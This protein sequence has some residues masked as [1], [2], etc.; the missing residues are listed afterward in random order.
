[1]NK[2][3]FRIL[4]IS[5]IIVTLA[6]LLFFFIDKNNKNKKVTENQPS[7]FNS[8]IK[9]QTENPDQPNNII[10]DSGVAEIFDK[11]GGELKNVPYGLNIFLLGLSIMEFNHEAVWDYTNTPFWAEIVSASKDTTSLTLKF[12]SPKSIPYLNE[13][14]EVIV[15]GCE[16]YNSFLTIKNPESI[17]AD[18]DFFSK[19]VYGDDMIGYCLD[20]ECAQVGRLCK[21]YRD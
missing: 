17:Q 11:N 10:I 18:L 5:I 12:I 13:Q 6:I 2:L 8:L 21:L 16:K 4:V 15:V 9:N 20:Q 1:M 3:P 7:A 19:I 14:K